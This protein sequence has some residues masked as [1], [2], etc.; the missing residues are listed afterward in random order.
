MGVSFT[1]AGDPGLRAA[2]RRQSITRTLCVGTG[3]VLVFG[4]AIGL[5]KLL[6]ESQSFARS[7][8]EQ[9]SAEVES[10]N[11]VVASKRIEKGS[12]VD[13]ADLREIRWPRDQV[14]EGAVREFKEAANL[15]ATSSIPENLPVYLTALSQTPPAKGIQDLLPAGHRAI[16]ISVD[17]TTG[18]EG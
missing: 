8:T 13:P 6:A 7:N 14:P 1:V 17:S 16:T 18:I 3:V 2:A 9:H 11:I 4:C 5:T 10:V 15:Y 12:K